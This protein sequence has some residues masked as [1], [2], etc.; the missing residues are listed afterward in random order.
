MGSQAKKGDFLG[1]P[2]F[3]CSRAVN[4]DVH[5]PVGQGVVLLAISLIN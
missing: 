5:F 4:T 3:T 2:K 1:K